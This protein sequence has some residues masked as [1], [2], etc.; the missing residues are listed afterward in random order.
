MQMKDTFNFR[1][2][3]VRES[4]MKNYSGSFFLSLAAVTV[5][6][7]VVSAKTIT[8]TIIVKSG[9]TYDG[10]GETI[11]CSGLGD[12]GQGEGQKPAFKLERGAKLKNIKLGKPGVDGIHCYG[13]NTLENVVWEDIGEDAL[14]VKGSSGV[15]DY[16]T[17]SGG[18]AKDG[19]DKCFQ[20]NAPITF[21][22]KNFTATNIGKLVRQNG[23]S[24]FKAIICIQ[25]CTVN[26]NVNIA[27]TDSKE[28]QIYYCG[29]SLNKTGEAQF[30]APS[31]SQIHAN[32]CGPGTTEILTSSDVQAGS[33]SPVFNIATRT[34]QF[35]QPVKDFYFELLGL[36]G[37]QLFEQ[38]STLSSAQAEYSL[39]ASGIQNGRYI[40]KTV[41]DGVAN[42]LN[43]TIQ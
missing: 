26:A 30:V 34:I 33:Q 39:P 4:K 28:T 9:E 13:N 42:S 20:I 38:R 24:G 7:S 31:S 15:N 11:T 2:N 25:N 29:G 21:T 6:V 37:Q 17:I 12:G 5:C 32:S 18:S 36:N 41:A 27:R 14:T 43:I 10:K 22:V 3:N 35:K 8:S 1:S 40:L 23:G 16:V 19:A